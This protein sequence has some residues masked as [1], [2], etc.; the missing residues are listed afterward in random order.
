M[1]A[2][3][4]AR[5]AMGAFLTACL[6]PSAGMLAGPEQHAAANQRLAPPPSLT[7]KDG[8]F[9]P[10]VFQEATDYA[11]GHFALRQQ[12]ITVDAVLN[13]AVFGISAEEDVVLGREGWLFYAETMEDHLRTAPLSERQL[14]A[15]AHTL[16]MVREYAAQRD[17]RLVFTVA[18]NKATIYPEYLPDVGAPL[19][20]ESDLDRL[21]PLL[22]EEGVP[23]AELREVLRGHPDKLYFRLDSHWNSAGAALGQ[24]ALL[25]A[26]GKEHTPFLEPQEPLERDLGRFLPRGQ[27]GDLYEMVYP[28][29]QQ[30]ETDFQFDRPFTFSYLR[31]PRSPE[32]QRIETE[33]P[34]RTGSLLMFRDSFGNNLYPYMAEEFRH[35]LFSR[36]MP[37]QLALLDQTGADTVVLELVERN[38]DYLITRPPVFPAPERTLSGTRPGPGQGR[39]RYTVSQDQPLEGY[40]RLEGVLSQADGDSPIYVR[41]GDVLWEATPA[42]DAWDQGIPFTLYVPQDRALEDG[43]V[44]CTQQDALCILPLEQEPI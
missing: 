34:S 10:N 9:N 30:E 40:V 39:A 12:L 20:A 27:R 5:L 32:D 14:W 36:S 15:G 19:S 13:A 41:L 7:R 31:Q 22:E 37:W 35:A 23:Y 16:A 11:A 29:G 25:T 8:S 18:P 3:T 26:L 4:K 43:A 24:N 6:I 1:T 21:I 17:A 2:K 44:L 38:L 28:A 42:G 33:H